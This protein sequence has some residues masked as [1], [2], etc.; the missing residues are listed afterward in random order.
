MQQQ[1]ETNGMCL[2]RIVVATM[3][4]V[5][6]AG[7]VCSA[8]PPH[9]GKAEPALEWN[10]KFAGHEGWIG[11][12]GVYSVVVGPRRILWLFSDSLI[13]SGDIHRC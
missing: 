12:D 5:A 6:S 7:A 11:G 3:M 9:V 2:A 10:A 4:I 1:R 13:A 8:A